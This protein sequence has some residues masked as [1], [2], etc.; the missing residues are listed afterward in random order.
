MLTTNV[1]VSSQIEKLKPEPGNSWRESGG[2]V[3]RIGVAATL[4]I[5]LG[6]KATI[7]SSLTSMHR[8]MLFKV[9]TRK[10][11]VN[12]SFRYEIFLF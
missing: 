10:E 12:F 9:E 7:N 8:L 2:A 11:R 5:Q 3:H 4:R 1:M 6:F